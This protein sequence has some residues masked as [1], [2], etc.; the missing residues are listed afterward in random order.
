MLKDK[1]ISRQTIIE[2]LTDLKAVGNL[3]ES[4]EWLTYKLRKTFGLLTSQ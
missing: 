3:H 1:E 2:D 4:L